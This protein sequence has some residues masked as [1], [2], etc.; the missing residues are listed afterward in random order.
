MDVGSSLKPAVASTMTLQHHSGSDLPPPKKKPTPHLHRPNSVRVDPYDRSHHIK[1][2]KHFVYIQ[3][4]CGMQSEAFCSLNH[5]F[6]TSLRLRFTPQKTKSA[7]HLH[8]DNS[9]RVDPYA[10]SHHLKIPK[11][12]V[13]IQYEC[14]IQSEACCTSLNHDIT[15]SLWLWSTPPPQKKTT[16]HLHMPNSVNGGPI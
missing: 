8:R 12:F 13:Y 1:E 16:P 14:G 10:H 11:H 2:L 4:G 7:P 5:D 9:V 3:Y 6:T 15:T